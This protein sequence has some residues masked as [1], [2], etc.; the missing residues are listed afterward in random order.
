MSQQKPDPARSRPRRATAQSKATPAK[1]PESWA[2]L[3]AQPAPDDQEGWRA[4][5]KERQQPWRTEPEI[6]TQ[7]QEELAKRRAIVPDWEKGIYPFGGMRLIRA[8]IEWLLATHENGRGPVEWSDVSQRERSGLDLRRADLHEL[9]LTGLPLARLIGGLDSDTWRVATDEQRRL[10]GV[11]L[12]GANLSEARL[13]G[14]ILAW[15]Q[16]EG[17]NLFRVQLERTNLSEARLERTNLSEARLEGANLIGARL[18]GADLSEAR[19]GGAILAW[20]RLEGVDLRGVIL[21]D[22][23]GIG[24]YLVDVRWDG[25]ILAVVDWSRVNIL[26]EEDDA[27]RTKDQAGQ[28]K[29]KRQRL[30]GYREAVRANRQLAVA[31][32]A[33]GLNEEAAHFAYRANVL[34]RKV[35]WLQ[36]VQPKR[37]LR[38]RS[39]KLNAWVFSH[40]LNLVA[41]YG[42]RPRRSFLAY[43]LVILSFMG[44]YLLTSQ[45]TMPHLRW[46]EALVLSLSSFHGRGFFPQTI[47]LGDPYARLAVT[48]AVLGLF[49]EISFIAT[50]TQRFFGK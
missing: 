21:A 47:T 38:Q 30:V 41:G 4:Y 12:I 25:T 2:H 24:P 40:L 6:D 26:G 42:Y 39:R 35:L 5:W 7:R 3:P 45:F 17:A 23:Q 50:F 15:A 33:Q 18:E 11:I 10:A 22:P 46:D 13:E 29:N 34:Q 48:E 19:L 44:L 27:Q 14:A 32:Q 31:L 1:T 49:I 20:A 28:I 9:N 37:S 8:D 43:L 36:M 16:L